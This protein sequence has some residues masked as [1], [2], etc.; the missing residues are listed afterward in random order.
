MS[1]KLFASYQ[2]WFV[3]GLCLLV[4]LFV[5]VKFCAD[6]F[7]KPTPSEENDPWKF[8]LLRF[9]TPRRQYLLGF[10][11]Y[12]GA[13]LFI[14]IAVSLM[15][16]GPILEIA[17]AITAATQGGLSAA[18]A[19]PAPDAAWHNYPTFPILV[20]FYIVGINPNLPKA[21][22]F[23][24]LLRRF[25]H[26]VAYIPRNMERV[27]NF[28]RFSGF[29]LS[30]EKLTTTWVAT[31]LHRP[32]METADLRNL[33]ISLDRAVALYAQAGTLAGDLALA[34]AGELSGSL[35]VRAFT[36]YREEI[37]TAG[38][39]LQATIARLD[40][41]A[42]MNANDRMRAIAGLQRD[43]SRNLERLL[44]IFA[45]A[46][47]GQDMDRMAERVQVLG[48]TS[49]FP[50]D[51]EIPWNPIL[52]AI[53]AAAAV[54]AIS[55]LIAGQMFPSMKNINIPTDTKTIAWML[56]VILAVHLVAISRALRVRERLIANDRYY[57]DSGMGQAVA[58][59]KIFLL[60]AVVCF[61]VYLVLNVVN[62]AAG[63]RSEMSVPNATIWNGVQ[64][65]KEYLLYWLAWTIVPAVCGVLT[66]YTIDRPVDALKER[67]ISGLLE[68][69][70]MAASAV[71][72]LELTTDQIPIGLRVFTVVLYSG[73]GYVLA[74]VLP[75]AVRRYWKSRE[76]HLPEK[77]NALRTNVQE[78][79]YSFQQFTDWLVRR[80]ERLDG[81]RP[82]DVLAEDGGMDRLVAL[83][84]GSRARIAV[85][86]R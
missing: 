62:F 77:I 2:E 82:L 48:F 63:V 72:V 35:N 40:D 52:Q 66:A 4:G 45:C 68:G 84:S 10:L 28:M 25:A 49:P 73:L 20:A 46:V 43:L 59:V 30:S 78:Y 86:A 21:L 17:K 18:P 51:S 22:D 53:G 15:G 47:A 57:S 32:A 76:N 67:I 41:L 71:L 34:D 14:F 70:I 55:W 56:F 42:G 11:V 65:T 75:K 64:F 3:F 60:C 5:I 12:C 1:L 24:V 6:Q 37:Q 27:F 23:E 81:K 19:T 61:P 13:L 29:E 7:V 50:T 36:L 31:D 26:R 58:Y 79:F 8:V 74:F 39:N 85:A 38:V 69:S 44:V 83:V 9:Q 54:L 16:P 33:S 80:N